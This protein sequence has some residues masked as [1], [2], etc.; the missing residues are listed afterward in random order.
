VLLSDG[1]DN[2]S[3]YTRD[4]ALEMAQK[5]DAVIYAISTNLTKI[6]SFCCDFVANTTSGQ[7]VRCW[8]VL[9]RGS[10]DLPARHLRL[11]KE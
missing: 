11:R 8:T 9:I 5:A 3:R 7:V 4:Q 10:L 6:E 1:D 2:N